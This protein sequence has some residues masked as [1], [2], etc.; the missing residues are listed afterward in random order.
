MKIY[1]M[2]ALNNIGC[3]YDGGKEIGRMGKRK[4]ELDL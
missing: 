2:K 1:Q 3:L 4:S